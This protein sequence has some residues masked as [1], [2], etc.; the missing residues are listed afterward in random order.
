MTL[1]PSQI[2]VIETDI[3]FIINQC[4]RLNLNLKYESDAPIESGNNSPFLEKLKHKHRAS[5]LFLR[6]LGFCI[7]HIFLHLCKFKR[8]HQYPLDFTFQFSDNF[9]SHRYYEF[10]RNE[11]QNKPTT[12][13]L[14]FSLLATQ[15]EQKAT[16]TPCQI[17]P[18]QLSSTNCNTSGY[19]D[20]FTV[21]GKIVIT[22]AFILLSICPFLWYLFFF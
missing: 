11:Q 21:A 15:S 1:E 2:P 5:A 22:L 19:F 18:I 10:S 13:S 8:I 17:I 14:I 16:K 3:D 9:L 20:N 12:E 7:A 4:K 6:F